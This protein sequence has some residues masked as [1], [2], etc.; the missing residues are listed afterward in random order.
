VASGCSYV[1]LPGICNDGDACTENDGC[2]TG[3]CTGDTVDCDDG[4]P[5]TLDDCDPAAGCTYDSATSEQAA[6]SDGNACTVGDI[7]A[8]GLCVPGELIDCDD[9]NVCTNDS[10]DIASGFC[11][12]ANN[13]QP[14][15]GVLPCVSGP[16]CSNGACT[17][18]TKQTDCCALNGD[19]DDANPCTSDACAADG[20]CT[21]T[22][23]SGLACEDGSACTIGDKCQLG[24][25]TAGAKLGCSDGEPC[26]LDYCVPASGCAN[27]V[28]VS[29][30]CSD[31]DACN[32]LEMCNKDGCQPASPPDCDD[33]NPCTIDTCNS[34]KGCQNA[35]LQPGKVC[36]D[37]SPCTT[38][39]ACDGLGSC[40]GTPVQGVDGC[41]TSVDDCDDGYG[42]TSD[43][44]DT[45]A[46]LC[47]HVPIDCAVEDGCTVGYCADGSCTT[48]ATCD[49]PQVFTEGFEAT[50]DGWTLLAAEATNGGGF[51]WAPTA[52]AA[53]TEGAQ[54]LRC[55]WGAGTYRAR[56]PSLALQPGAYVLRA[57]VRLDIDGTNC[58]DNSLTMRRNGV[59]L[60]D[61]LCSSSAQLDAVALPFAVTTSGEASVFEVTFQA[62]ASAPDGQRGAWLDALR[63]EASPDG[64]CACE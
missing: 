30:P 17:G 22:K 45:N 15:D 52:T 38:G 18:G 57:D 8:G 42:C 6:C 2:S 34:D 23:I 39:D 60:G 7:C 51:A 10:C 27:L 47:G 58:V 53:A 19:C 37:G 41:C 33:N 26:T 44:C 5:C 4:N 13:N 61:A 56:T 43:F 62:T 3:Q 14:C 55:G 59:P 48:E 20:S 16:V 1:P 9:G 29:G 11:K 24:A 25:C 49:A 12:N 46:A 40:K 63:I 21:S 50:L 54:V 36:D 64:A 31:G 28:L 32:G 35:S